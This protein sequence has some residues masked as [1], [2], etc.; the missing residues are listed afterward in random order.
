MRL[1]MGFQEL[2]FTLQPADLGQQLVRPR[3]VRVGG[4][5][6]ERRLARPDGH[7][8]HRRQRRSWRAGLR[9]RRRAGQRRS[10]R[11]GLRRSWRAGLR[12]AGS[13]LLTATLTSLGFGA[14]WTAGCLSSGLVFTATAG[15]RRLRRRALVLEA[16]LL[17]VGQHRL[18]PI[19]EVPGAV[20][21]VQL[22]GAES[23]ALGLFV[24]ALLHQPAGV[25]Q[26]LDRLFLV[27]L[28]AGGRHVL[29]QL[30]GRVLEQ[31][32]D[33]DGQRPQLGQ[34]PARRRRACCRRA[35]RG[36]A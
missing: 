7:P 1:L 9:R 15:D 14:D 20:A 32:P 27:L 29:A 21:A 12:R 8:R 33:D 3:P 24:M 11:A 17:D 30:F 16:G 4:G 34:R 13:G 19:A 31:A 35:G 2:V 18:R 25:R 26:Q 22:L 36:P 28:L 10:W 23:G 6:D 5:A